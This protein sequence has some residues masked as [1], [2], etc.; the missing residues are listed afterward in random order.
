MQ[1]DDKY[2]N[3]EEYMTYG[4]PTLC[5]RCDRNYSKVKT[6]DLWPINKERDKKFTEQQRNTHISK[7]VFCYFAFLNYFV[8]N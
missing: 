8:S 6:N 2:Y 5:C 7:C 4:D 3:F 1:L